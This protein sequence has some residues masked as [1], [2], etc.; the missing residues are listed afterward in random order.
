LK[1]DY[2]E[3]GKPCILEPKDIHF[4][5]SHSGDWV[6]C[7]IDNKPIGIDV[8][9]IK[10]ID[11]NI[12]RRFFT[13]EEYNHLMKKDEYNRIRYF[14][15]LWTLKESYIKAIGKGLKI[16]L[17]SFSFTIENGNVNINTQNEFGPCFFYQKEIDNN[18]IISV[19]ALNKELMPDIEVIKMSQLLLIFC[20]PTKI[21]L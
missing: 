2:N 5:I 16:P 8:E 13:V 19:C 4:N 1:F 14:Y 3:Y 15:M 21:N 10:P 20:E 12:A 9:T 6:V 18:H 11:L 17:N 7:A